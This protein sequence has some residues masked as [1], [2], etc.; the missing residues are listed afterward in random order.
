MDVTGISA[1]EGMD[2]QRHGGRD[3]V[4]IEGIDQLSQADLANN[5]LVDNWAQSTANGAE[6]MAIATSASTLFL[7]HEVLAEIADGALSN[8]GTDHASSDGVVA[9]DN[10]Q[11]VRVAACHSAGGIPGGIY[12]YT[13]ADATALDL[14][15]DACS[16][17]L[18]VGLEQ[19]L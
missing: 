2:S 4:V 15:G 6:K 17:G 11:R 8:Q 13:G 5:N 14:L 18:K 3:N 19:G 7:N 1:S 9:L 12:A 10:G 16:G